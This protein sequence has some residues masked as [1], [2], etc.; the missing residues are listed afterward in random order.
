VHPRRRQGPGRTLRFVDDELDALK[1]LVH[2]H[3]VE[4]LD[5]GFYEEFLPQLALPQ[6]VLKR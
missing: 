2:D 4:S 6:E 5:R 1:P 3:L